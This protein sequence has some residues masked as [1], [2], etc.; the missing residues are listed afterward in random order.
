M[1]LYV[2]R[3]FQTEKATINIKRNHTQ[4]PENHSERNIESNI[5]I[6]SKYTI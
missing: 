5:T 2:K 4:A 3:I 6:K 1:K